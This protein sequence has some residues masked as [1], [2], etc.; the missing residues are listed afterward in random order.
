MSGLLLEAPLCNHKGVF[1]HPR[2]PSQALDQ[3]ETI[4]LFAAKKKKKIHKDGQWWDAGI[5]A[6]SRRPSTT[7]GRSKWVSGNFSGEDV[8]G[9]AMGVQRKSTLLGH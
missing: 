9:E 6:H 3:M 4:K 8:G 1:N 2:A 5:L 7:S